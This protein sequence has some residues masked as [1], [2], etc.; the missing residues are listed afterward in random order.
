MCKICN[1]QSIKKIINGIEYDFCPF[2]GFLNKHDKYI[3]SSGDEHNRYL[4]HNNNDDNLGYHKYQEKFYLE[5]KEFLGKTNLDYGCG[6]NHVLANILNENNYFTSFYD[7]YFYPLENYKKHLYDAIILEEVIEHLKDPFEVI[8]ELVNLLDRNGKLIIRTQFIPIN[9]FSC[10]WWYLR[11]TTHI[12]FFDLKTFKY[13]C[14]V[15]SLHII[16]C[17]EKDLIILQK[18]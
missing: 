5:I 9:I 3:L 17:N 16:Y 12:S 8:K 14:E 2:C 1:N 11:D 15:F 13:L 6:D 10:N 18:E 4:K 7:L